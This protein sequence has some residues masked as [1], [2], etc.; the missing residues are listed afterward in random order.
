MSTT[1]T[2]FS[3]ACIS[4]AVLDRRGVFKEPPAEPLPVSDPSKSALERIKERGTIRVGYL[5]DGLP[6]S[7]FNISGDLVGFDVEMAHELA[8]ELDVD[9]ELVPVDRLQLG[10]AARRELLRHRHG[11]Y[12]GD[13]TESSRHTLFGILHG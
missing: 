8:K 5:T 6:Y 9:L 2:G 12:R 7:D 11:G 10:P 13:D 4:S 1:R 3:R